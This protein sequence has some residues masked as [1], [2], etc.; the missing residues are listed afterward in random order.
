MG[1]DV[2]VTDASRPHPRRI[3]LYGVTGS[4]KT[5]AAARISAA[6][7]IP[8]TSADDLAWEAGWV[9]RPVEEQRRRIAEVCS[10]DDWVLDTAYGL[11]TDLVLPRAELVVALDYPRR[12][13]LTRLLR[14]TARRVVLR[15][16]AC[17]GNVETVG[18]ALGRDSIVRWHF[19]SF[20]S[21]RARILA[22]QADPAMPT[23]LR[24]TRPRDLELWI[25][26]LRGDAVAR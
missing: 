9:Q 2:R 20:H 7:G 12:V 5:H 25:G 17:N 3:L 19:R 8:W 11:W 18:R 24:F 1:D 22:W 10:A 14:R 21:K 13:S 15:T 26:A 23:V 4:G 16:E 6:T